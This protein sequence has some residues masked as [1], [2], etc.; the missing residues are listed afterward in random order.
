LRSFAAK[1][2]QTVEN[3]R[4]KFSVASRSVAGFRRQQPGDGIE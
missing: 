1:N 2:L 4:E 3:N